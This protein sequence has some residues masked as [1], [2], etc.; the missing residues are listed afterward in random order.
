MTLQITN[1]YGQTE[2][3]FNVRSCE[4][5]NGIHHIELS[6]GNK[7]TVNCRKGWEIVIVFFD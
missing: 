1:P 3:F 7:F 6:N 2:T 5:I 4:E